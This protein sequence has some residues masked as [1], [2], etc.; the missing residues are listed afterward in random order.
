MLKYVFNKRRNKGYIMTEFVLL[1]VLAARTLV[2]ARTLVALAA[3]TLVALA[4]VAVYTLVA[5][6][7][8]VVADT[9]EA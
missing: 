6:A 3:R 9:L 7:A 1:F 5:L 8:V 2:V 4:L